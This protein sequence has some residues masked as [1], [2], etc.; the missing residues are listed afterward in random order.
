M[1]GC[2]D[3]DTSTL[4]GRLVF[5]VFNFIVKFEIERIS[6]RTKAGLVAAHKRGRGRGKTTVL[7]SDPCV[8]V[9]QMRYLEGYGI[10]E[11]ARLSKVNLHK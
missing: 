7:L 10:A 11:L 9:V 8:E 5:H 6:E 1:Q 4:A 2:E 3:I